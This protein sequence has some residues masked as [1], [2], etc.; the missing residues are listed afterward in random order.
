MIRVEERTI[1]WSTCSAI[2]TPVICT[3][4]WVVQRQHLAFNVSTS[5]QFADYGQSRQTNDRRAI[6]G[7]SALTACKTC[8]F[9]YTLG[10]PSRHS[11]LSM[12][13][14]PWRTSIVA[15]WDIITLEEGWA[16]VPAHIG[17]SLDHVVANPATLA[18]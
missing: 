11:G 5:I 9:G 3:H 12:E 2:S 7:I 13:P 10:N 18:Y 1:S 14:S 17:A 6:A 4:Y 8:P 16:L 15:S